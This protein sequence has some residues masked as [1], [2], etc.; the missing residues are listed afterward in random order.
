L[1]TDKHLSICELNTNR[2]SA[3]LILKWS[4]VTH[5]TPEQR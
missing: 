2:W 3:V 4:V 5:R 1:I